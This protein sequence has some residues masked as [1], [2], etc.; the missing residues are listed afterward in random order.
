V[1]LKPENGY[2]LFAT[3][4]RHSGQKI[5]SGKLWMKFVTPETEESMSRKNDIFK[6]HDAKTR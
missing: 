4:T 5:R 2:P 1:S 6:K 3:I